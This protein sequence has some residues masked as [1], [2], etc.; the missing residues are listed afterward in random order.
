MPN[1][2]YIRV[3]LLLELL[4]YIVY[5]AYQCRH[6]SCRLD[7]DH[8]ESE[9]GDPGSYSHNIGPRRDLPD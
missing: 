8:R 1:G 6:L 9:S 2:A 5:I 3:A 7:T 4:W